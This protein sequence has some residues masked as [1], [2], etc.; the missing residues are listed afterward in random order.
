[1]VQEK[2]GVRETFIA[3]I[4]IGFFA[5]LSYG[6]ARTLLLALFA[7]SLGAEPTFIG[8]AV[9]MSTITGIFFKAPAGTL[10]DLYGRRTALLSATL[11]FGLMPFTYYLINDFRLLVIIRFFHGFATAIYV[12]SPVP[13]D[14]YASSDWD[15]W[16]A[17]S[18][19]SF[20]KSDHFAESFNAGMHKCVDFVKDI[21]I[22]TGQYIKQKYKERQADS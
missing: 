12:L 18:I 14:N 7:K 3:L 21:S 15:E 22:R 2:T 16:E 20:A 9:G 4:L 1:M 5:R 10:S 8:L 19:R 13:E 6:M 11:I 17:G